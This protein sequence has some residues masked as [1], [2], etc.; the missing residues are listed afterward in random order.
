MEASALKSF[1]Q[2]WLINTL[3]VLVAANVVTGL[4]Y[5]NFTGLLVASLLLGILNAFVRPV[6]MLLSLPLLLFSLGLFTLV[7]N[8]FLLFLVGQIVKSFHVASFGSAFWGALVIS[9][10]SMIANSLTG[11]GQSRIEV[12]RRKRPPPPRQDGGSGPVIDV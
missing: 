11:A 3:A 8:A 2:R 6:I 1:M 5:D 12:K 4:A 7:I 9:V 10:V